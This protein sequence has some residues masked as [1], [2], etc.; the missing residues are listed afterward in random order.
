MKVFDLHSHSTTSDGVLT[1]GMLVSRAHEKGVDVLAL[2]DHD[3]MRGLVE[4]RARA[5]TL[6]LEVV[7]G[8][9]ISTTWA[10]HTIHVLGLGVHPAHAGLQSL[11]Q[12]NRD[13]RTDRARHMAESLARQGIAGALEG[14]YA[15]AANPDLIGRTHFARF[16][17]EDGH[18]RN[19]QAVFKKY[20]IKGKPGFVAHEWAC[21]ADV[22]EQI[23]AAEGQAVLA[24][25]GRYPFGGERM[26]QLLAEFR[27]LGG[28]GIEVVSG[29]HRADQVPV[30]GRLA[31]EFGLLASSGS[32]FHAPDE[33]GREL[34][35]LM[36]LPPD[37]RPIWAGW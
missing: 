3:D 27:D 17:V 21:L 14:A 28:E 36:P 1:P 2:T 20:L 6:G 10:G 16:L 11:L 7:A 29:G 26:R 34:G 33:G 24:H 12:A 5:Q 35:R 4:A 30:Y 15:F 37:C 25:P 32:D 13:G 23:R 18:A 19:M 22:V 31:V 9:E 8:V